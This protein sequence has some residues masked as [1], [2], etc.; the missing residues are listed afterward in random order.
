MDHRCTASFEC[1]VRVKRSE[2]VGVI[3]AAAA[4]RRRAVEG[5]SYAVHASLCQTATWASEM[6]ARWD[7]RAP[8]GV[9]DENGES[10]AV[11]ASESGF[12]ALRRM[13]PVA[14]LSK[15]PGPIGPTS[16]ATR[17]TC[18]DMDVNFE[19]GVPVD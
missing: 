1:P 5:G 8:A 19:E 9:P 4:A 12:G 2:M 16:D 17:N 13:G 11:I 6:S 3:G 15:T 18:T 14:L 7:A 10:P